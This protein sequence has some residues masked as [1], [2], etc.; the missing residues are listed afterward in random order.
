[1]NKPLL[2]VMHGQCDAR[3]NKRGYLSSLSRYS[4]RLPAEECPCLHP[5]SSHLYVTDSSDDHH[6][7]HLNCDDDDD[8]DDDDDGSILPG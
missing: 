7:G 8:D 2:S 1:M 3:P 5:A 4:L 6:F